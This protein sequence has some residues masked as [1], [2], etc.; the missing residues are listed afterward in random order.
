MSKNLITAI[1]AIAVFCTTNI[2][3]QVNIYDIITLKN[4]EG[5]V[6]GCITEQLLGKTISI[7]PSEAVLQINV[8]DIQ[9]GKPGK[10]QVKNDSV[11]IELDI[12][13]LKSDGKS[14][15]GNIFAESPGQW[16]KI[17]TSK[18]SPQTYSYDNI[19]KIGKDVI[20]PKYNI[21]EEYGALDI[22]DLKNNHTIK[23]VIVEQTPG[24]SLIIKDVNDGKDKTIEFN[25]IKVIRKEA[26]KSAT[27]I[28]K[29]SA[30][31]DVVH[32]TKGGI[33]RGII[34][35]QIPGES[36]IVE[37]PSNAGNSD[38][39]PYTDIEK[40]SREINQFRK[41]DE[42]A[43][44]QT[45]IDEP[46]SIGVFFY[47]DNNKNRQIKAYAFQ[48]TKNNEYI[49]FIDIPF[50]TVDVFKANEALT[51]TIKID[52]N[53][54]DILPSFK[55]WSITVNKDRKIKT[56]PLQ[57]I[58]A[59]QVEEYFTTAQSKTTIKAEKYGKSS[60]KIIL[61]PLKTG[62]YAITH[63]GSNKIAVFGIK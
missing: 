29:H 2:S 15:E 41:I 62:D 27:D 40:I 5:V 16:Y 4:G 22:L 37:F 26:Y 55:V 10:T 25:D 57:K 12:I 48:I 58:V 24:A 19:E 52:G 44:Q 32:K 31:L 17:S 51:L 54:D 50:K 3:G 36:I 20:A 28:F 33:A 8:N 63:K 49:K 46:D 60:I 35:R 43:I 11:T 56:I 9:G 39:I 59:K 13:T 1:I 21:F 42:L 38:P 53:I 14:I 18:L 45:A 23:G 47:K 61:S 34:T 6:K 30:Y 7:T